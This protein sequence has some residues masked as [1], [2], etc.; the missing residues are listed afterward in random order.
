M[1]NL[2][3]S[4]VP[5]SVLPQFE[6]GELVK[7]RKYGYR[8]V[9]VDID[10]QCQASEE[11]YKSNQTQPEKHQP[12]YHVLVDQAVHVTYAAQG[13]LLPDESAEPILHPMTGLFFSGFENGRYL[14][15]EVPW[16]PGKP[17]D[18]KPPPPI[19]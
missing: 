3:E 7:H 1:I 17:P 8:G 15:N 5:D 12:W 11:W 2:D 18:I 14:R 16:K 10:L 9:V 6:L 13:N 4:Y 19:A